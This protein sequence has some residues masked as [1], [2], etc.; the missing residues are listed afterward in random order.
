M[1][2]YIIYGMKKKILVV[3][4]GGTIGSSAKG[5]S[6][7]LYAGSRKLLLD[8]YREKFGDTISFDTKTPLNILSENVQA[9]DLKT[10]Y[11]CVNGTNFSLYDGIII[12]HGT[13]T[14]CFTV[15]WFSRV[16]RA[17][18]VPIVFVSALFPLTDPRSNGLTNFSG[19]VD[20]IEQAGVKGVYCAFAND[21]E[22]CKIHIG[23]RLI[24]PDETNGFYHSVLDAYFAEIVDGKVKFNSNPYTPAAE[25]VRA[26][27][28]ENADAE[29]STE[30]MLITMRSLLNFASYDFSRK[31]PKAVVV[32]LS[33]SGT[34]CTEGNA[35][36]FVN[37][38]QYCKECGVEVVIS[39]VFSSAGVY[40]S[41]K[42]LP[43]NVNTAYD[44]TLEMTL[45]KVMSAIGAGLPAKAYLNEEGFFDKVVKRR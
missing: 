2:S 9:E 12:T 7:G 10:L 8:A 40:E 31:K 18:A 44:I 4:T 35:L 17:T 38:A 22:N 28:G 32:E 11:D 24:Y 13:D 25:E 3:F 42:N 29:L 14:L 45:A 43:D 39:P 37:F 20:F 23:S 30:V 19:A 16:M 6:V 5:G 33:H 27:R 1:R 21:N 15:N 26:Y 36:N 34:V 41:M